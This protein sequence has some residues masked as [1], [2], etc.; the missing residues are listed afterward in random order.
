MTCQ[1]FIICI[2]TLRQGAKVLCFLHNIVYYGPYF[3]GK[4]VGGCVTTFVAQCTC[5]HY[6]CTLPPGPHRPHPF[7]IW[8]VLMNSGGGDGSGLQQQVHGWRLCVFSSH[9][10]PLPLCQEKGGAHVSHDRCHVSLVPCHAVTAAE[11]GHGDN[12]AELR[13]CGDHPHLKQDV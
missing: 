12:S 4:E 8:R 2:F 3:M 6:Y 9:L 7:C 1:V 10:L 5:V 11:C 13:M